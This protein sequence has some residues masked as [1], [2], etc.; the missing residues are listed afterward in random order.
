MF[1]LV[2]KTSFCINGQEAI[3]DTI[4]SVETALTQIPKDT[5]RFRPVNLMLLDYQ[6]PFKNGLEVM[7]EIKEFYR[8]KS[9]VM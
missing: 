5:T 8:E 2:D 1:D 9:V 7:K 6:M 4:K 3:E